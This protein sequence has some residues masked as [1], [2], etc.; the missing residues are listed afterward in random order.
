MERA[1]HPLGAGV[2]VARV[3]Y[4]TLLGVERGASADDIKRAFRKLALQYHPDR[5]PDDLDA[6]RRFKEIAE[7]YAVLSSPE[8]RARVR[9]LHRR[10]RL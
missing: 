6:E 8:E 5:N 2:R 4:Y 10:D 9:S 3:D 7:A 1:C